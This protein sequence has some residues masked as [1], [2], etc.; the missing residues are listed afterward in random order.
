MTVSCNMSLD[1]YLAGRESESR[2]ELEGLW[3]GG[4]VVLP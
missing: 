4:A 1:Q 3:L 2:D